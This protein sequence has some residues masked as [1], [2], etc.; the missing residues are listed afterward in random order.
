MV[1]KIGLKM[2]SNVLVGARSCTFVSGIW[3]IDKYMVLIHWKDHMLTSN[4]YNTLPFKDRMFFGVDFKEHGI[5]V[6]SS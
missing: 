1:K 4:P 3:I 5:P 2:G 6:C